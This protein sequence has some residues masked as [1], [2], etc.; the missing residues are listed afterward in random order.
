MS[1]DLPAIRRLSSSDAPAYRELRL[2]GLR[3]HPESFGSSLA[4]EAGK[5]MPWFAT[6]LEQRAVFAADRSITSGLCG[7]A[8]FYRQDGANQRHKGVL[9]GMFVRPDARGTGLAN[10]LLARVVEHASGVVEELRLTVGALNTTA[11]RLYEQ[12]GFRPYGLERRALKAG[13]A[14]FD[15][16]LM[17]LSLHDSAGETA[18]TSL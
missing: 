18:N 1:A 17:A 10:R 8:G 11:I 5:P 13:D 7:V 3:A 16:M 12:A 2:L 4:E 14:Y 6:R 15:E 9:W